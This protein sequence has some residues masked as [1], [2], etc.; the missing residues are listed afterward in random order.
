MNG[1]DWEYSDC[2]CPVCGHTPMHEQDCTACNEMHEECDCCD[3]ICQGRGEC[4]HGDG[5][6]PCREC[7]GTGIVRWCPKCGADYWLAKEEAEAK[8]EKQ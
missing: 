3:D 6:I 7:Q 2:E 8:K 1:D 5:M 4:I